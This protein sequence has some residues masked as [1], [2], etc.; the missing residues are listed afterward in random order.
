MSS[1]GCTEMKPSKH[2]LTNAER[3]EL[4][5]NLMKPW[6][7]AKATAVLDIG[8][9]FARIDAFLADYYGRGVVIHLL[10]NDHFIEN[11]GKEQVGFNPT[12]VAWK[13]RNAG[14]KHLKK[15]VPW[16]KVEGHPPNPDLTI[17]ANLI[18]SLRALGHHFQVETYLGLIDRSLRRGGRLILDIRNGTN[19]VSVLESAGFKVLSADNRQIRLLHITRDKAPE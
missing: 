13:D 16:C 12:T 1:V 19:G 10:D 9:G 17:R 7:P 4:D 3:T 11:E 5:F 8:C 14:I 6:I 15:T 2:G 18:V